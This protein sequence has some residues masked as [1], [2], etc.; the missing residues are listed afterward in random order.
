MPVCCH[1]PSTQSFRV[2][3]RYEYFVLDARSLD[4]DR[5][6]EAWRS[7]AG[8]APAPDSLRVLRPD[9]P[10]LVA[11]IDRRRSPTEHRRALGYAATH[12]T[13][14]VVLTTELEGHAAEARIRSFDPLW[15]WL[16]KNREGALFRDGEQIGWQRLR[17]PDEW[18][19]LAAKP[20]TPED[21]GGEWGCEA[22]GS[23]GETSIDVYS[24][25]SGDERWALTLEMPMI[26]LEISIPGPERVRD[27]VGFLEDT[28][29]TGRYRDEY[30]GVGSYRHM[31]DVSTPMGVLWGT[32]VWITK[33]GQHD[34]RYW[35]SFPQ[36]AERAEQ[37]SGYLRLYIASIDDFMG[38]MK[39]AAEDLEDW[40]ESPSQNEG[41]GC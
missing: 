9:D 38:A 22:V 33:C 20:T 25:I 34:D 3:H 31:P 21:T 13:A 1:G 30:L 23:V 15:T 6:R 11:S 35:L 40:L 28:V 39:Q 5:A 12:A 26:S 36:D 24:S 16:M 27:I 41:G 14:V 19:P 37:E 18:E 7:I 32:T 29:R 8:D 2:G 17:I 10:E 4:E